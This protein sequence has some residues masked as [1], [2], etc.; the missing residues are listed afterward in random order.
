MSKPI[1]EQDALFA[2]E[3]VADVGI[4]KIAQ[5]YAE[6]FLGAVEAK[7]E[8]ID[9]AVDE[10]ISFIA[11]VLNTNAKFE[12]IL[13]ST[14]IPTDKKISVLDRVFADK[15]SP[16]FLKFLKVLASHGRLE[17]VRAVYR[18]VIKLNDKR[19][20]RIPVTVT[21]AAELSS[22]LFDGLAGRLRAKLGGEP[23]IRNTV[24]P[25]VIGGI[26]V[27]VGDTIYDGSIASQLLN[28][29]QHII[30][31]STHEIQSRRDRFRNTEGN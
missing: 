22:D 27:R 3:L 10:F 29:R 18:E 21:T 19:K 12:A 6:A 20:G 17:I 28:V 2:A 15:A 7:G 4:E 9:T 25:N 24:D 31:R 16:L 8:L 30:D 14:V 1:P 5:M 23:I 11:D 13:A 26:V